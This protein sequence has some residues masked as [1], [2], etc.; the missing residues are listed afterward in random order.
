VKR[1]GAQP[2]GACR[3]GEADPKARNGHGRWIIRSV[4]RDGGVTERGARF[5]PRA[6]LPRGTPT[7]GG[8]QTPI[9]TLSTTGEP[10]RPE[11]QI[12][13]QAACLSN[14]RLVLDLLAA[15]FWARSSSDSSSSSALRLDEGRPGCWMPSRFI[16]ICGGAPPRQV[17]GRLGTG[18]S[19]PPP[20]LGRPAVEG[21]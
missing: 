17:G 20:A 4:S 7:V 21:R 11:C 16:A 9:S 1:P 19:S 13:P 12:I 6:P 5:R 10:L 8:R 3:F 15:T 18:C 14:A 2:G